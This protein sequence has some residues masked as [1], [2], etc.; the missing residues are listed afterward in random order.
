MEAHGR[1][2][3][4]RPVSEMWDSPFTLAIAVLLGYD[5]FRRSCHPLLYLTFT[6]HASSDWRR[7]HVDSIQA[8]LERVLSVGLTVLRHK[9]EELY[10]LDTTT[11]SRDI[12]ALLQPP[13]PSNIVSVDLDSQGSAESIIFLVSLT[14]DSPGPRW[15]RDLIACMIRSNPRD[16]FVTGALKMIQGH[17]HERPWTTSANV[18]LAIE[19]VLDGLAEQAKH[20]SGKDLLKLCI[21]GA[22]NALK[23]VEDPEPWEPFIQYLPR[24]LS[25]VRRLIEFQ[26]HSPLTSEYRPKFLGMLSD[27]V[28]IQQS[29]SQ[30]T[31]RFYFHIYQHPKIVSEYRYII[32]YGL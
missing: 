8:S 4:G 28:K 2:H 7:Q 9:I 24:T 19:L 14:P 31:A 3:K 27:V 21:L 1:H 25:L 13:T 12:A 15:L 29:Q 5:N 23:A 18:H 22:S 6:K 20:A 26:R 32:H 16:A 11:T 17:I 30:S 10:T